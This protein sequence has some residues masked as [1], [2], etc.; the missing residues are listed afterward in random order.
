MV[1]K[2]EWFDWDKSMTPE[3]GMQIKTKDG[4]VY[5]IGDAVIM[6]DDTIET[7][8]CGCCSES[9]VPEKWKWY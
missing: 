8:G 1:D 5:L 4:K 7:A 3:T 6:E 2:E 9:L